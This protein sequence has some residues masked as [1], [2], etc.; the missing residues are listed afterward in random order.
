M[1]GVLIGHGWDS[2][3]QKLSA[4]NKNYQSSAIY[5]ILIIR[6]IIVVYG[7]GE[8]QQFGWSSGLAVKI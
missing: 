7:G 1:D 4:Q 3:T 2:K 8:G 6:L 5:N